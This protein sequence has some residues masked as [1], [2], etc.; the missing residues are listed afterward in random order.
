MSGLLNFRPVPNSSRSLEGTMY[1]QGVVNRK[2]SNYDFQAINAVRNYFEPIISKWGS[3]YLN[4]FFLAG[5]AA[6]GVAI[7]GKSDFDLFVSVNYLCPNSLS[8]I[9]NTLFNCLVEHGNPR[10][11]TVRRQNVSLGIKGL[12]YNNTPID[13]DIV[14][15]KQQAMNSNYHSLYKSKQD[16]W[17]QTNVRTHINHV[18]NSGRQNFIKLLKIW[19]ECHRLEFPSMNLEL[20]VLEALSGCSYDITLERGFNRVL[21]YLRDTFSIARL[22]DPSNT[23]NIVSNDMTNQEKMLVAQKAR[24]AI[25]ATNWS[26]VVW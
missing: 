25:A 4:E 16:S 3:V 8:D 24:E 21:E 26:S 13:V 9:F 7:K 18:R 22:V 1:L 14:P 2:S 10:G 20:S 11:L 23:N 6:K 19:R 12:K 5:S 15:A 17:T